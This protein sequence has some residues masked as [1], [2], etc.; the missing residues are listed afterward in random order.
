M[1]KCVKVIYK[2]ANWPLNDMME[3]NMFIIHIYVIVLCSS[4]NPCILSGLIVCLC[5]ESSN[6]C[7]AS[8]MLGQQNVYRKCLIIKT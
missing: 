3:C 1:Y 6:L 8:P 5:I 2:L 4:L 7:S